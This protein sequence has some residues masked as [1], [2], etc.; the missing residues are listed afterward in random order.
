M[1]QTSHYAEELLS[2]LVAGHKTADLRLYEQCQAT[3]AN[4]ILRKYIS[5]KMYTQARMFLSHTDAS[6]ILDSSHVSNKQQVR[7]LYYT[8]KVAA[9]EANY[10]LS[11]KHITRAIRKSPTN[12]G[13]ALGF[14]LTIQKLNIVTKLLMGEIPER[15]LFYMSELKTELQPYFYLVQSVK[16]GSVAEFEKIRQKYA[17]IF[18][19]DDLMTLID[20][21]KSSVIKT[22]LRNINLAY[23]KISFKDIKEKLELK[24]EK[25]AEL[26]CAK[27]IRDQI[28]DNAIID[29]KTKTLLSTE[30]VD[31]YSTTLEPKEHFKDRT[32]Y[33][34]GVYNAA[35]KAHK[36]PPN[37]H[38]PR[39][40]ADAKGEDGEEMVDLFDDFLDDM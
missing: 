20:R 19:R 39:K 33:C 36:Y 22:G 12:P 15:S 3:T 11:D 18:E 31:V 14:R 2:E 27:A 37:S 28:I 35:M 24:T 40:E 30:T 29:P 6:S 7:Y 38:K 21:L 5:D 9:V 17:P 13:I 23:S 32:D 16:D 10:A 4:L 8:G 26:I 1:S 34:L 25:D